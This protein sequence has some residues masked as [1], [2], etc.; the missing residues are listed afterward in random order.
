MWGRDPAAVQAMAAAGEN[1]RHLPGI[2]LP[3]AVRVTADVAALEGCDPV[4]L[5]VPAQT[6]REVVAMAPLARVVICAKGLEQRSGL[7]LSEVARQE[8]PGLAVSVLSGPSFAGELARGMPTAVT[9]ASASLDAARALAA[10]L[11]GP[12]FRLYPT[13]D[14][15]GVEI[16]GALKNVIAIAAGVVMGRELGENA[17]AA[18]VTRGLAELARLG[19][20]LGARPETLMGLSGLGD[21]VLT[22][23]SLTSRNTRFGFELGRGAAP[24][25]LMASGHALSEGAWTAAAACR[26]AAQHGVELPIADAVQRVIAGAW[27]VDQAIEALVSRP[28]AASE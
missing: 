9:L 7:R 4:L 28:L 2:R 16:G 27:R 17:R 6:V 24:V 22:A 15:P 10:L 18:V 1:G 12:G 20:R 19:R 26:L 13:D 25:E 14:L 3:D 8:R 5:C 21:L 23:T 11:A